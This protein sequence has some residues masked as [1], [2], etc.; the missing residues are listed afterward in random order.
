MVTES[1][2]EANA[3][4]SAVGRS[5]AVVRRISSVVVV[6]LYFRTYMSKVYSRNEYVYLRQYLMILSFK[7]KEAENN[8]SLRLIWI[9]I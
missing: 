8:R 9:K 3:N 7:V 4:R 1:S 6:L 5:L 2:G